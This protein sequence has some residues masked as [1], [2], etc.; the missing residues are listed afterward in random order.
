MGRLQ[1]NK[2]NDY[3][4]I[5]DFLVDLFKVGANPIELNLTTNEFNN[6]I[7]DTLNKSEE[8]YGYTKQERLEVQK[9]VEL[10]RKQED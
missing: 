3:D 1:R 2:P 7:D 10:R 4:D 6:P 9:N 8:D 5:M